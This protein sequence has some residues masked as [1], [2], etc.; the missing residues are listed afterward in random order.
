MEVIGKKVF[1]KNIDLGEIA[2]NTEIFSYEML[3]ENSFRVI[4]IFDKIP[5]LMDL[6]IFCEFNL[7]ANY[8]GIVYEFDGGFLRE[9]LTGLN[10]Y[11]TNAML[12]IYG[13][14]VWQ[15]I[16]DWEKAHNK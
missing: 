2:V 10:C 6:D 11:V 7:P 1:M 15:F 9:D 12:D 4:K 16:Y 13:K 5:E 8:C 14:S 3:V